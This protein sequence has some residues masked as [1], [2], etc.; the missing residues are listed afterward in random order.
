MFGE[1]QWERVDLCGG[2]FHRGLGSVRLGVV[3]PSR[4]FHDVAEP[5]TNHGF[6]DRR[7][8][9]GIVAGALRGAQAGTTLVIG[10]AA[11]PTGL[12][13]EAVA[14]NTSG[15]IMA[16]IYDSLV[17]YKAGGTE[18]EPGIAERWEVTPDGLQYTFHLRPG[19]K[20]QDGT[21]LD[22]KAF[23]ET[24]ARQLDKSSPI[25]IYNTGPGRRV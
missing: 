25:Y 10:I 18:V 4:E 16:A 13:P 11:D 12:D 1:G 19:V 17:R 8:R 20:F 23:I 2:C 7:G 21:A 6:D 24:I 15:F 22:A 3:V 5:P 9:G 14:N